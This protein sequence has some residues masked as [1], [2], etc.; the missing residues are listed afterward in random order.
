VQ[1]A[2]AP[3]QSTSDSPPFFTSSSQLGA[4]QV[5]AALHTPLWQSVPAL[6]AVPSAQSGQLPPQSVATSSPLCAP[7]AQEMALQSKLVLGQKKPAA[8]S[9][10][11]LQ[12]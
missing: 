9:P 4:A 10:S 2:Q 3:A 8:Q 1:L 6:Q 5:P 12:C 7:S 11:V